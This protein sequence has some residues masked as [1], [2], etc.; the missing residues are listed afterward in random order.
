MHVDDFADLIGVDV[1][2]EDEGVDTI[3]GL[4]GKRLGRVPIAGATIDIDG[5]RLTAEQGMGRRNRIGS[6][7]AVRVG[8][9][10]TSS[11]DVEEAEAVD[12]D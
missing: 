7:L 9:I 11:P 6:V 4:M 2:S 3:L 10:D 5:W 8:P 12:V 1:E